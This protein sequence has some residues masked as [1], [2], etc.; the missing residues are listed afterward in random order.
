MKTIIW[1]AIL[2][3][4]SGSVMSGELSLIKF[5]TDNYDQNLSKITEMEQSGA[6][7]Y[8]IFVPDHAIVDLS[9]YMPNNNIT[10]SQLNQSELSDK[11]KSSFL[12][13][14][15]VNT[16]K[17]IVSPPNYKLPTIKEAFYDDL[18]IPVENKINNDGKSLTDTHDRLTGQYMIGYI[19]VGIYLMESNGS[20]ENWW[21]AAEEL[22]FDQIAMGLN[23]IA[24]EADKRG[25]KVVWVYPPVEKI[26][27]DYE[28]INGEHVPRQ[29]FLNNWIFEWLN[30]IYTSHGHPSEWDGAYALAN[31]L[32]TSYKTN[33]SVEIAVV[34]NEN[35]SDHSFTDNQISYVLHTAIESEKRSPILVMGY[36]NKSWA[37]EGINRVILHEINHIFGAFDEYNT[38]YCN[39]VDDCS[40]S[41][42][43]YLKIVNGNCSYC[44]SNQVDC[45]MK[46]PD[47]VMCDYT[48]HQIGWRDSDGDG[49]MDPVD[50][51][52]GR[53]MWIYHVSPGDIIRILTLSGEIVDVFTVTEDMICYNTAIMWNGMNFRN[54]TVATGL[55]YVSKNGT[56]LNKFELASSN[57]EP[58]AITNHSF[59]VDTLSFFTPNST[60]YI[61]N[62]IYDSTNNIV[63]KPYFDKMT[64]DNITIKLD[65]F[66][67]PDGIYTSELSGWRG[68]GVNAPVN[69]LQFINYLC[70]DINNDGIAGDIGDQVY[71][72]DYQFRGGPPPL[73]MAS[74][75]LNCSDGI[76]IEDL[77]YLIDYM[78]HGGPEP[79]CCHSLD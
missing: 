47:T 76:D 64:D 49:A 17:N 29:N 56:I 7:F 32:R 33:W 73:H 54:Q 57:P 55:Y 8:H 15:Y 5:D 42:H 61:R 63:L 48:A 31:E 62:T 50:P 6:K 37:P 79:I 18:I 67:L 40:I 52:S 14:K 28:P 21:P 68:D 74:A 13:D 36:R 70:A 69:S 22:T 25:V 12:N 58:Q 10:Y 24:S 23:W 41:N 45:C 3:F 72:V 53:F 77:V 30:D 20:Q 38:E 39:D 2:I 60:M 27:T 4:V 1:V 65:L 9:Y 35:D 43:N 34:M 46:W 78:F 19:T 51:N 71:M 44:T 26:Y 11:S 66:G 59:A 75:D 16:F